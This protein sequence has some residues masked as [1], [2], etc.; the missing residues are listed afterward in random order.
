LKAETKKLKQDLIS[1]RTQ[2][3]KDPSSLVT[4]SG[5]LHWFSCECSTTDTSA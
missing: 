2:K 1:S 4:D 3:D 5:Q